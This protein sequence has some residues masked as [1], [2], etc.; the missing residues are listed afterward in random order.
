MHYPNLAAF[1]LKKGNIVL[2]QTPTK[3]T[4]Q[5][6]IDNVMRFVINALIPYM[7]VTMLTIVHSQVLT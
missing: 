6:F 7:L 4:K 2:K 1:F 3:V 5:H